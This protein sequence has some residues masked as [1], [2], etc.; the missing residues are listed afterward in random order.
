MNDPVLLQ[1]PTTDQPRDP[2][3]HFQ[4][5]CT[6]KGQTGVSFQECW[7]LH[8]FQE[9][10]WMPLRFLPSC[11]PLSRTTLCEYLLAA[12]YRELQTW[13]KM[14]YSASNDADFSSRTLTQNPATILCS[15]S[16][17]GGVVSSLM[18]VSSFYIMLAA[19]FCDV[20]GTCHLHRLSVEV[21]LVSVSK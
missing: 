2:P 1:V 8:S 9:V 6:L 20:V 5:E 3:P 7:D 18:I 16:R 17:P 19:P 15:W 12:R 14:A 10:L 13:R 21:T 4:R 11:V